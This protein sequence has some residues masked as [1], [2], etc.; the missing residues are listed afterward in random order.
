MARKASGRRERPRLSDSR[1][2]ELVEEATVDA[3]GDSEQAV[4]WLTAIEQNVAFPYQTELFGL[5]VQVT[6]VDVDERDEIVADC[7]AGGRRRK[8]A[9]TELP[10]PASAVPGAEWIEAY[11][12]WRG[13]RR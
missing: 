4:G 5:L 2:E 3:Y 6:A 8:I 7:R 10:G 1:Y 13:V 9:L 12:R 11:C